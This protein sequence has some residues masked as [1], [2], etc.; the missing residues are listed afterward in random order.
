MNTLHHLLFGAALA[1]GV[2]KSRTE[3]RWLMAVTIAP[4]LDGVAFW[5]RELWE[6]IHHTFGHNVFFA[7]G[8][9]MLAARFARD[10]R[11]LR[12]AGWT[13]FCVIVLHYLIDLSISA[14]WPIRPFWP[15]SPLDVNLGNFVADSAALDWWLRVPVQWTL[16]AVALA[17]TVWTWRAH[18]RSALELFS[19]KLD[20][21][22]AGYVA[23]MLARSRCEECGHLAGF[24]CASCGAVLCGAH[25][26]FR[27]LEPLCA[28]CRE[29]G[30]TVAAS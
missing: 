25:V 5:N 2:T 22:I 27:A 19:T 4:D 3:R 14:T 10:G 11:R 15:F 13:L 30:V 29:T 9:A 23:R 24:K 20:S 17:L 6:R 1:N 18:G 28:D 8:A 12:L 16:V 26:R 7:A 21:L